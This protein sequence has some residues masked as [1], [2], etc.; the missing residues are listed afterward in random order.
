MP[1]GLDPRAE[2]RAERATC[3]WILTLPGGLR[4]R[5]PDQG[6]ASG[7]DTTVARELALAG[8]ALGRVF[9]E[10]LGRN[11]LRAPQRFPSEPSSDAS[12][13]R[14]MTSCRVAGGG[15]RG[16]P[17]GCGAPF[18]SCGP[19]DVAGGPRCQRRVAAAFSRSLDETVA[20]CGIA[21]SGH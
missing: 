20:R 15:I 1:A 11:N 10:N 2:A 7:P 3:R 5:D 4:S 6:H 13:A 21:S 12:G 19:G 18:E 17:F 8:I 9:V 16:W 14:G